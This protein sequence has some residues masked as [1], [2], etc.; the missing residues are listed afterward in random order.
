[1]SILLRFRYARRVSA[2]LATLSLSPLGDRRSPLQLIR[3]KCVLVR[4]LFALSFIVPVG[5][6]PAAPPPKAFNPDDPDAAN[7]GGVV[8]A[9]QAPQKFRTSRQF[10]VVSVGAL[11]VNL[12]RQTRQAGEKLV[13]HQQIAGDLA[14]LH[15]TA[16][17]IALADACMADYDEKGWISDTW[18]NPNDVAYPGLTE[19]RRAAE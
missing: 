18:L 9:P 6:A 13:R 14:S 11:G 2:F 3:M 12:S 10:R 1:M 17:M 19:A 8:V 4:S 5:P 7:D 15:Q 16:R